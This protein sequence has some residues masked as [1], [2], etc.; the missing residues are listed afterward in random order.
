MTLVFPH[1]QR[2]VY[3]LPMKKL[4]RKAERIDVGDTVEVS[5]SIELE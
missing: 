2:K 5:L 1:S 4:V 3:V